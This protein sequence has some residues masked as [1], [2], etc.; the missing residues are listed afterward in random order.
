MK[1]KRNANNRLT[2]E[3]QQINQ[4]NLDN[5]VTRELEEINTKLKEA[6]KDL[7]KACNTAREERDA[8]LHERTLDEA[9]K[10]NTEVS[11]ET[12]KTRKAEEQTSTFQKLGTMTKDQQ[13]GALNRVET[14]NGEGGWNTIF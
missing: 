3:Q 8:F 12:E 11:K 13:H 6:W 9:I 14:P 10:N 4:D 2:K 5:P 1:N 7:R